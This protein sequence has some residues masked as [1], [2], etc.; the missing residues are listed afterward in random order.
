MGDVSLTPHRGGHPTLQNYKPP[1]HISKTVLST[2]YVGGLCDFTKL[3]C[4][5]CLWCFVLLRM[6]SEGSF[7]LGL[8]NKG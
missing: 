2:V 1:S 3:P 7:G 6:M 8:S 4:L 5:P